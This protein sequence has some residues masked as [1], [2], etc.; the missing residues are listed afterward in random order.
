VSEQDHWM[1]QGFEQVEEAQLGAAGLLIPDEAKR[2]A[3]LDWWLAAPRGARTPNWDIA[4]T[5]TLSGHKEGIVLIEAKAHD[6]ELRIAEAGKCLG[7]GVDGVSMNSRRN[8]VRIGACIDEANLALS[9]ATKLPWALSRDWCYQISNRFDWAWKLASL[10]TPVILVYLGFLGCREMEIK[11]QRPFE[12]PQQWEQLVKDHSMG[13]IPPS[14]W[15]TT[16]RVGKAAL[17]PLSR[18]R[19]Q[20]LELPA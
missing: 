8:H 14:V 4:S 15:G 6:A 9:K 13:M 5:C 7:Q 20:P 1:P 11:D 2:R 3:L 18:S 16:I 12:S 17:I 10:G 19:N